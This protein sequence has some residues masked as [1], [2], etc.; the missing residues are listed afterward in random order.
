MKDPHKFIEDKQFLAVPIGSLDEEAVISLGD[1]SILVIE[2]EKLRDHVKALRDRLW[3]KKALS[4][5][6]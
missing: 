6:K 5:S 2:I 1:A 4:K 3:F